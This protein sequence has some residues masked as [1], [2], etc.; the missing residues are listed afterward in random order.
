VK[1]ITFVT[2]FGYIVEL[3]TCVLLIMINKEFL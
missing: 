3:Q 2:E 1:F